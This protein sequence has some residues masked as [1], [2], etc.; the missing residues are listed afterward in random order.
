M[1]KKQLKGIFKATVDLKIAQNK[2]LKRKNRDNNKS[3]FYTNRKRSPEMEESVSPE[4]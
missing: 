3:S 1:R 4:N 2:G